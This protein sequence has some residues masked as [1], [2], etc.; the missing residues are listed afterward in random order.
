MLP[1]P[2]DDARLGGTAPVTRCPACGR[3]VARLGRL[4][5]VHGV[6]AGG[7]E[8]DESTHAATPQRPRVPGYRDLYL[9]GRGG[10][11]TVFGAEPEG[12]GRRVAIKVARSDRAEA[13][14]QLAHE[15]E[16]LERVGPPFVPAVHAHGRL[17]SGERFVVMEHLEARTLADRLGAGEGP[18]P[19]AFAVA[20]GIAV[21][22]SLEAIH[23][24]G[25]VHRDLKP[26]NIFV[27]DEPRATIVDFG[28]AAAAS[29]PSQDTHTTS[30]GD[31]AGTPDYMAP[32]QCEGRADI[33]ARA[34]LYAMGIILYELI[35]GRPPFW[36]PPVV[37]HQSHLDRRPARFAAL[38]DRPSI[39]ATLEHLVLRC[40]AKDRRD[41]FESAAA[42]RHALEGVRDELADEAPV[43]VGRYRHEPAPS[44]AYQHERRTLSLLFFE[45]EIDVMRLGERV[46]A[47]GG[48]V[49]HAA[50]RRC[51][52]AHGLDACENPTRPALATAEAL[53]REGLCKAVRLDV[54]AVTIQTKRDGERRFLSPLFG[55]DD[56]FPRDDDPA[57]LL[58]TPAAR[59][60]LPA[61]SLPADVTPSPRT[62]SRGDEETNLGDPRTGPF[63]GRQ[64]ILAELLD[65][66]R[67]AVTQ[68]IPSLTVVVAEA[69]HGKSRLCSA[70]LARL[71]LFDVPGD[72]LALRAREPALGGAE[73]TLR[74][75]LRW[76]LDLPDAAPPDGG[77]T[78][79]RERLGPI[80]GADVVPV[81][82]LA[83]GWV[84]PDDPALGPG[85]RAL[86]AAPG[87]LR[88]ALRTGA[89]EALRRRAA[90]RPVLV[91]LD[92]AQFADE[93][94]LGAL[95]YATLA[96][97]GAPLWV[98]A[99]GRPSFELAYPSWGE[100]AGRRRAYRLGP[101]D[102]TSASAMCRWLLHPVENLPDTAVEQLV[103][104]SQRSPLL[105]AE[106]VRGIKREGLL[107][108]HAKGD[109]WY[110]ATDE[111]DRLPEAPL[112]EWLAQSELDALS[113]A[114]QAHARLLA[115]L[116]AEV[117]AD[118]VEGVLLALELSGGAAALP[119]DAKIATR[120]LVTAGLVG[121]SP[122]GLVGF[123]HAL[124]REAVAASVPAPLRRGIHVAA[125]AHYH[126]EVAVLED[127][128]LARL[129]FH[130]AE[131][132]QGALAEDAYLELAERM[133]ARH[134]YAKAEQLYTQALRQPDPLRRGEAH[135]GRGLMRY[136][137]GRYHDA[138]ADL[139]CARAA[140]DGDRATQLAILL[141][142]ATVLDWMDEY[143]SSEE[144]VD[145]AEALMPGERSPL[146][147]ARLLLGRGRSLHRFCREEEAATALVRAAAA[148]VDLGDEGY[149]TQVI[150]RLLLGF[151]LQGLGRLDEGGLALDRVVALCEEHGD[152]FHLAGAFSNRALLRALLG[153]KAE[154]IADLE[155]C[156]S[157]ARNLGQRTL[158][159]ICEF[160]AAEYL[161]LMDDVDAAEPHL[162]R[163]LAL[164]ARLSGGAGRPVTMLLDARLRLHRG[165]LPAA[166][167]LVT[168]IR[169]HQA[170]ARAEGRSDAL[171][172][173]SEEILCS[174][175][176]LSIGDAGAEAWDALE[177][178]SALSSVGQ[179][180]IEVIEARALAAARRGRREDA[181]LALSRALALAATIPNVMGARLRRAGEEIQLTEHDPRASAVERR[182]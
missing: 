126:G 170:D 106:L 111:L 165:E 60:T 125:V 36:G 74:E 93:S 13:E 63:F 11:G 33:D 86:A 40:L 1:S 181:R 61:G 16:A 100:R 68:A 168:R 24:R 137:S 134:A 82:A 178:R 163:A 180:R 58:V 95:E 173:P 116:G 101:L 64:A 6:V 149:E 42:L 140:M 4:C 175:V 32:E 103:E 147:E 128:P 110:L 129:A 138:L 130:A 19:L 7:G 77:Q 28:L 159:M 157:H 76:T 85:L 148:A 177:A 145:A 5:P 142:E 121:E 26:E 52:V 8:L 102:P 67:R 98:C 53:L 70:L 176:E 156:L 118:D 78:I 115:L 55:R 112:I 182:A 30:S 90:R 135:R 62:D 132:G 172:V 127:Q 109:A 153:H 83:L 3:R 15:I 92:D 27:D 91:V 23:A 10:F 179:E 59:A 14:A 139:S 41:R 96:E 99:L 143:R 104:R 161:L 21:L 120:R 39:P 57:G 72:V 35:V 131:A 162:R 38:T 141:D 119:L 34:D 43:T 2:Q 97:A 50:G 171:M 154:M 69:G 174:M 167:A 144:R 71:D 54:A 123:R 49:A 80:E 65:D 84:L 89:G 122:G 48:H 25:Y 133:R 152:T 158:E 9:L 44:R 151:I 87:A 79:L 18:I 166:G 107:R 108:R 113:P 37:V 81:L 75:L 117:H 31:G 155:R 22:R 124:V 160:N 66:G 45:A 146:L 20:C 136:R 73:D 46:L 47:L 114:L 105:L 150:A 29:A 17:E 88:A 94:T 164:D 12:T 51:V 169:A 56:R